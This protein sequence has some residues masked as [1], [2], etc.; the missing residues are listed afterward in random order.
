VCRGP[1]LSPLVPPL[2]VL[3]ESVTSGPPPFRGRS[4]VYRHR[5]TTASPARPRPGRAPRRAGL[6]LDDDDPVLAHPHRA[7]L[8]GD[9]RRQRQ[10]PAG[11]D[12][13][14]RAVTRTYSHPL[15]AVELALAERAVVVRAKVLQP[16]ELVVAVVDADREERPHLDDP[17]RPRWKLRERADLDLGHRYA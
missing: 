1:R 13:E 6:R 12:V 3:Q 8:D 11:R 5:W 16:L 10:R 14:A 9:V 15:A 17:D 4:H 2:P 7:R